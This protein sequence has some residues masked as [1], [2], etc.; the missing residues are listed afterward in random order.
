MINTGF[1]ALLK[2]SRLL[3]N[4]LSVEVTEFSDFP[5][6]TIYPPVGVTEG[7]FSVSK[8]FDLT[9]VPVRLFAPHSYLTGVSEAE[10]W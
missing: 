8:I 7:N 3:L 9:K 4:I 6:R 5:C 2:S 1:M 10:L